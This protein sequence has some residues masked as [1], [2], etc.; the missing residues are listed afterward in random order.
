MILFLFVLSGG[1][2]LI[3]RI[4]QQLVQKEIIATINKSVADVDKISLSGSDF[5]KARI[6]SHEIIVDGK[7]YDI[8]SVVNSGNTVEISVINDTRE[9]NIL[10]N[11]RDFVKNTG[12]G[13]DQLPNKLVKLLTLD[14][15]Y[16][17]STEYLLT[18]ELPNPHCHLSEKIISAYP[19]LI[20]PPPKFG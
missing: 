2:L 19:A 8:K 1:P 18:V 17:E 15:I 10:E 12:K 13:D 5:E 6:N 3:Y 16:Y 9:E 4:Q 14:Y 20:F 7:L 11:I